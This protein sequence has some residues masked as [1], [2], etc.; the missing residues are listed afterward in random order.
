MIKNTIELLLLTDYY[1]VSKRADTAKG[2]YEIPTNWKAAKQIIKR[3]IWQR[4]LK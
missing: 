2:F 4:K 1:K 3:T